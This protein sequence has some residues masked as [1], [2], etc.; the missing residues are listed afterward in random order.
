MKEEYMEN[1]K[2]SL[3]RISDF[4]SDKPWFAGNEVIQPSECNRVIANYRNSILLKTLFT[5]HLC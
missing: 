5:D 2:T 3:K 1:V 4:L